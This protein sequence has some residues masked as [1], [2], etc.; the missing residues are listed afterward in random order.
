MW[1]ARQ[2]SKAEG[3][4]MAKKKAETGEPIG[5]LLAD[6]LYR[7]GYGDIVIRSAEVARLITEKTGQ[8]FSRQR[9][10]QLLNAVRVEPE[11]IELLAQAVGVKPHELTKKNKKS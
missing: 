7:L 2:Q 9:V 1:R 11:T 8:N 6:N 3:S 5:P 10:S 4:A